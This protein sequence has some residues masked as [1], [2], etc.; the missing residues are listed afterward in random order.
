MPE[1][2]TMEANLLD[3]ML[4]SYMAAQSTVA[5][6]LQNKIRVTG[7]VKAF[8]SYVLILD[9]QRREILYLHAI[10]SLTPIVQPERIKQPDQI[11]NPPL[12]MTSR[13]PKTTVKSR[14]SSFQQQTISASAQEQSI[15]SGMKEGLLKW[16]QEQKA[17]K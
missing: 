5:V 15:N 3:R 4:S 8:D 7:K 1:E 17:A 2:S 6:T 9:G 11:K 12:K 16:M 13:D 14:P 10:S